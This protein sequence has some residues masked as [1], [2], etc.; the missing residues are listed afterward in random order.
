MPYLG[1]RARILAQSRD[2][3][4]GQN[5]EITRERRRIKAAGEQDSFSPLRID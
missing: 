1:C 5:L 3:Q 4:T 2:R